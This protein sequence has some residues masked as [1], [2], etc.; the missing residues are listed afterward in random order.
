MRFFA[1]PLLLSQIGCSQPE[2]RPDGLCSFD[3]SGT[4]TIKINNSAVVEDYSLDTEITGDG[5]I[6]TAEIYNEYGFTDD[7]IYVEGDVGLDLT[8]PYRDPYLAWSEHE[9]T[10]QPVIVSLGLETEETTATVN[11][12]TLVGDCQMHGAEFCFDIKC[13]AITKKDAFILPE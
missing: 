6:E 4:A 10:Y 8:I 11:A 9:S 12:G 5:S 3:I 7:Y 2:E 13:P 1:L